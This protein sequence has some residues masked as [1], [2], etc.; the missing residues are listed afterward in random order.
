MSATTALVTAEEYSRMHFDV[1]T[2]LV[3]GEIV[4]PCGDDGMTRPG[5]RHGG[6]CVNVSA[7]LRNWT[8]VSKAGR[9]ASNDSWISTRR[10]PDSVRGADVA[11][12]RIERLP[13]GRV[14]DGPTDLVPDLCVEVVSP[15][16][17]VKEMRDKADEY[18]VAGVEE[19]WIVD[20]R[21]C[22]V[23]VLRRDAVPR[24]VSDQDVL[25]TPVLPGFSAKVSEFF[26][27]L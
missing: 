17:T 11:Y 18:L 24:V 15:S 21:K 4:F 3:R 25:S 20:P 1:P 14:P 6:V 27:D 13:D 23:L 8:K 22:S 19:M 2:E 16:N 26:E 9:V 12:I 7:L 10:D 5:F